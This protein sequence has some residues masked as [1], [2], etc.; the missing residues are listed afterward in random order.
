MKHAHK[1]NNH[2]HAPTWMDSLLQSQQA[3]QEV[4]ATCKPNQRIRWAK[5]RPMSMA[6]MFD[7]GTT[8]A[9][10]YIDTFDLYNGT[11]GTMT[12]SST[13]SSDTFIIG[14]GQTVTCL[15]NNPR[16]MP[17][18]P[19]QSDP[20]VFN[21]YLNASDLLEEFIRDLG[22]LDVKQGEV[23]Q[24]PI[25]LFINWLI[26]KAAEEDGHAPPEDIKALPDLA[27][28]QPQRIKQE[29]PRCLCCGRFIARR[30]ADRGVNFCNGAHADKYLK[31]LAA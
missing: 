22:K 19:P 29:Q 24:I 20:R 15:P 11:G 10:T 25:E 26:C 9:N 21:R 4:I 8:T 3:K 18:P 1:A 14:T 12:V 5:P 6:S 28:L 23:L 13:S 16:Y 2:W 31:A 7:Q 17:P 27:T 30:V